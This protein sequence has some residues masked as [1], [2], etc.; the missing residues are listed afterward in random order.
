[1]H[2]ERS[3]PFLTVRGGLKAVACESGREIGSIAF[4]TAGKARKLKMAADRP[5]MKASRDDLSY[6]MVRVVDDEGRLVPD[7]VVSVSFSVTGMGEVAAVG[8]V[9]SKGVASF[10]QPRRDTFHSTCL[11]VLRPVGK[12]GE[13]E[14][15][16]DS[17]RLG[18]TTMRLDVAE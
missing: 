11:V 7:A 2:F 14:L 17:P 8:N 10:R 5:K 6:I 12:P 9:S 16:A 3:S 4:N 18:Y 13:I 1:M 15:R